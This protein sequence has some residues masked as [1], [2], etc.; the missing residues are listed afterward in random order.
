MHTKISGKIAVKMSAVH[1]FTPTRIAIIKKTDN[2][3]GEAFAKSR[4]IL[5]LRRMVSSSLILESYLFA[6]LQLLT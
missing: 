1:H 4:T 5:I 2:K 3:K 6:N